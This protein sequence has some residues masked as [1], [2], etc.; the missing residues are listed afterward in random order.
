[1]EEPPP[2]IHVGVHNPGCAQPRVCTSARTHKGV[3]KIFRALGL[4]CLF[5]S[6]S[7]FQLSC[8]YRDDNSAGSGL[9]IPPPI[10]PLRGNWLPCSCSKHGGARLLG[11]SDPCLS[12]IH[13]FHNHRIYEVGISEVEMMGNQFGQSSSMAIGLGFGKREQCS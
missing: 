2:P 8:P 4:G 10:L 3:K 12:N 13:P 5:S 6:R 1:M 11:Q 9:G 7:A